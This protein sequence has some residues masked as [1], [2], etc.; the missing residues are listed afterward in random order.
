MGGALRCLAV[1]VAGLALAPGAASTAVVDRDDV[2]GVITIVD[3]VGVADDILVVR[4]STRDV[5]SNAGPGVL[6]AGGTGDCDLQVD[7]TVDCLRGSSFSV[8]L[9]TGGD[10]FRA[11]TVGSPI[12]VAGGADADDLATGGGNDVLAGGPGRD[13]LE[14]GAGTNHAEQGG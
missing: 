1:V 5:I 10:R 4:G 3:D 6:T 13:R 9:G 11:P 14:G 7:G 12:S 8:D 2:T